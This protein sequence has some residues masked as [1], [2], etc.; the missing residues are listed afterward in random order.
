VIVERFTEVP[1]TASGKLQAIVS[2]LSPA[3]RSTALG[4]A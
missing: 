4:R 3:Q 2:L 1:R